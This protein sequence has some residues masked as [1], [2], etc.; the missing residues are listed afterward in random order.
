M[1]VPPANL[2]AALPRFADPLPR[3]STPYQPPMQFGTR[4]LLTAMLVVG[5]VLAVSRTCGPI[6]GIG[7]A[8]FLIL[9]CAHA[10][11]NAFGQQI[12]HARSEPP[13]RWRRQ[14]ESSCGSGSHNEPDESRRPV[15]SA[16]PHSRPPSTERLQRVD[17]RPRCDAQPFA[18]TTHPRGARLAAAFGAGVGGSIASLAML[19]V[20]ASPVWLNGL[21][22]AVVSLATLG[23]CAGYLVTNLIQVCVAA[24]QGE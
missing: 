12:Y 3:M 2:R 10:F 5:I 11:G 18:A 22:V 20:P 7:L 17:V 13:Q 14:G 6:W 15:V 9:G 23:G 1:V 19:H 21:V 8:W 16:P 24:M 4:A